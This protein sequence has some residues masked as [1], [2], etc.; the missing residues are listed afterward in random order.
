MARQYYVYIVTNKRNAV[1]YTG[2]TGDLEERVYQ[3]KNKLITGFTS[4]YNVNKLVYYEE[5]DYI[6]NAITREKQIKNWHRQW[7]INL[8]EEFNPGWVDLSKDWSN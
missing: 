8:I 7:K 2:V 6:D 5:F 3:H 1:L 4:K